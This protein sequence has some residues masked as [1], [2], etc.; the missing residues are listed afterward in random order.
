MIF[1]YRYLC[2]SRYYL[3]PNRVY[4]HK[5]TMNTLKVY[6]IYMVLKLPA[7]I[8]SVIIISSVARVRKINDFIGR[9]LVSS[10]EISI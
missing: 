6:G 10:L 4:M 9:V 1:K 2:Y 7:S 3:R 8:C 5:H